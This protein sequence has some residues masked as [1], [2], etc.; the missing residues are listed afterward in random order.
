V[1]PAFASVA[2]AAALL[3]LPGPALAAWEERLLAPPGACPGQGQRGAPTLDQERAMRCLTNFARRR[4]GLG[5]LASD[6]ALG[7]SAGRK[8]ADILRCGEFDHEACGRSFSHWIERS[9]Y[10]RNRCWRLAENIAYG[11][12]SLGSPRAIFAAWLGSPGH[13]R[14]ILGASRDLGVGLRVGT[15]EGVR[16]ARVWTQH[17]GARC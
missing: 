11:A 2:L 12:G 14:N 1:R 17:F 15:I 13:R 6:L 8:S 16:G 5:P 10:T 4:S 3:A 7:R 9:G